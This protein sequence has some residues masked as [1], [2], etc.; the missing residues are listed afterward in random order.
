M[1][2]CDEA[3]AN[4]AKALNFNRTIT[5][6]NF[7]ELFS[8]ENLATFLTHYRFHTLESGLERIFVGPK[9]RQ[10]PTELLEDQIRVINCTW[11]FSRRCLFKVICYVPEDPDGDDGWIPA[12][13]VFYTGFE[14]YIHM[15]GAESDRH[16][17]SGED[18]DSGSK[19]DSDEDGNTST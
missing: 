8:S 9:A 6:V 4:L 2:L 19:A 5:D 14:T 18:S 17:D 13:Y 15:P 1:G 16:S 10:L 3:I 12:H 11:L 7:G